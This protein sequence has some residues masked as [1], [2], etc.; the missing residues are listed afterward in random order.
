MKQGS[1]KTNYLEIWGEDLWGILVVFLGQ[2]RGGN[3]VEVTSR[4]ILLGGSSWGQR[5]GGSAITVLERSVKI[6]DNAMGS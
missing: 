4:G 6:Q 5:S 2:S 1:R 3:L